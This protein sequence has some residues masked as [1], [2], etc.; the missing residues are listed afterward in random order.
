[1]ID[2][3]FNV[4]VQVLFE[5]KHYHLS[6]NTCS[7]HWFLIYLVTSVSFFFYNMIGLYMI[8]TKAYDRSTAYFIVT[9][10]YEYGG[11]DLTMKTSIT[12]ASLRTNIQT[13][14]FLH[15]KQKC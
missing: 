15:M 12:T 10:T 14:N 2:R 11:T 9:P 5:S 3:G 8:N 13:W 7:D 4:H 1:M 6:N